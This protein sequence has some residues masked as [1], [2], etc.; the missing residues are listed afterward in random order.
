MHHSVIFHEQSCES[1]SD[2]ARFAFTTFI[3]PNLR[4]DWRRNRLPSRLSNRR[5]LMIGITVLRLNAPQ[6]SAWHNTLPGSQARATAVVVVDHSN[7][8]RRISYWIVGGTASPGTQHI[9]TPNTL[10]P[11]RLASFQHS[12]SL[13]AWIIQHL[14]NHSA[15]TLRSQEHVIL[16]GI[17]RR[18]TP[19]LPLAHHS[20]SSGSQR[21]PSL[22]SSDDHHPKGRQHFDD[23]FNKCSI[24]ALTLS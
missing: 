22:R 8:H 24:H 17:I 6:T 5:W 1:H 7:R 14:R 12:R 2:T 3:V 9:Q 18:P 20:I 10:L 13:I 21:S 15:L 19:P 16:H 11:R 23:G 4:R